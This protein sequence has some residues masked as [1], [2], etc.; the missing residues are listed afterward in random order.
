MKRLA[1]S[2]EPEHRQNDD[3][4]A[5][6]INQT[7]HE[8]RSPVTSATRSPAPPFLQKLRL[9][10]SARRSRPAELLRAA[11]NRNRQREPEF[12][13]PLGPSKRFATVRR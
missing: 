7:V 8:A 13:P 4:E 9:R 3:D 2:K 6:D 10:N 12:W 11:L 1:E 5:Y